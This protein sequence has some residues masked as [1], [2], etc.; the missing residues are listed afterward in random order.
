M[1]IVFINSIYPNPVEP[2]MGNFIK[3][4][5]SQYPADIDVEVIAPVP[6]F[7][8]SRRNKTARIPFQRFEEFA[9]REIRVWHPRF[10]L[11]PRNILRA[12]VP[13]FEY[14]SV[15]PL[16]CYLHRARKI[17]CLH[18]NFCLPDGIATSKLARRLGI[19]Y[20]I[21]EHRAALAEL[22][23]KAYLKRMMIPAYKEAHRVIAVSEHTKQIIMQHRVSS[24]LVVVIPNGIDT[25]LFVPSAASSAIKRLIYIGF[26][27]EHKGVQILLEAL[28]ILKDACLSLT[29]VGDGV[30]R[31]E[32]ERLCE[33]F[34]LCKQVS[35]V[36]ERNPSEVAE[37]LRDHDALVHPSFIESF[38]IVVVEA[39]ACGLPVVAT[40]NGGSE[41]IVSPSTGIIVEPGDAPKLAAGIRLLI[42]TKWD[43]KHIRDYASRKY[44]I[45]TVV[46]ETI[47]LYPAEKH[48][49]TICHL[50]SVHIRSDVRIFYKQCAGLAKAG[51]KTHL[52]V[53]DGLGNERKM[54][55]LIHDVG[56]PKGRKQRM[57]TAPM[58]VMLK[59]LS[60]K[61]DIYQIHDPELIPVAMLLKVI[62]GKPVIY[63][64]HECYPELFLHKEYLSVFQGKLVS[65][66]IRQL[67]KLAVSFFDASI[68]AT[69]HISEQFKQVLV[70]HNYPL[71]SEWQNVPDTPQRFHSR[72]I[73]Y[74]GSITRERGLTQLVKALE[75][76]D[77]TLHLAGAYEPKEYREELAKLR[78]FEKVIEYG[79]VNRVQ[80][81]ELLAKCAIGVVFL[82]RCPNYIHS[83]ATK[84]FEYMAA[85]LP[86]IV[87][88]LPANV[89]LLDRAG[90]GRYLDPMESKNIAKAI[91]ELLSEPE[92]LSLMG[93]KGKSM[94]TQELSWEAEEPKYHSLVQALLYGEKK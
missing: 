53:A 85:G 49:A 62:S 67:E 17:D 26:L 90:C 58:K 11:F 71:L 41:H 82:E 92:K 61:A 36:G 20:I 88:D 84:M 33:E 70:L 75:L 54:A 55:V 34:G 9:G 42:N 89:K 24:D 7:L 39:M 59:A 77:C 81:A 25:A 50:S 43:S 28:S 86:I 48:Q 40:R 5:L 21:T 3:K 87:S 76:V 60:L 63:D 6:F 47:R 30:Y 74:L 15:L 2:T 14:L 46:N 10:A 66:I 65:A 22:L 29:L 13:Y 51:L 32:L 16:L 72:N 45:R 44:D 18:A 19:P 38:G 1:R 83:L 69:E 37:L 80:A 73:C 4:N 8:A 94:V 91:E 68:A 31:T 78:G 35:F 12:L 23:S 27:V 57:L 52:V 79:Y 93:A 64:I 56:L